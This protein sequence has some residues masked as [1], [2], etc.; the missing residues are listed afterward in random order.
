M[1][2]V[3]VMNEIDEILDTYCD[4]C[5]VKRQLTK[6]KGKTA[7]HSFCIT[8]CTIGEHLKFLGQEMNKLEK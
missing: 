2:K 5:F 7:A 1:N 4:G 8:T 6:D 3:M